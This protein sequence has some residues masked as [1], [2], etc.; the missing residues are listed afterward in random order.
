M[1]CPET[2]EAKSLNRNM[3]TQAS[4]S[5]DWVAIDPTAGRLGPGQSVQL[6][7]S[8]LAGAPPGGARASVGIA[9]S[10]G[11]AAEIDAT[12]PLAASP[13]LAATVEG[14]TVRAQVV[15][16]TEATLTLHYRNGDDPAVHDVGFITAT[17]GETSVLPAG[18]RPLTWWVTAVD[19]A[20]GQ[21]RT[22][23]HT[24]LLGSC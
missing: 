23:D 14:C 17:T 3:I 9:G 13:D 19:R 21:A 6:H 24:M 2:P 15:D 1:V 7:V 11:S 16:T 5:A 22:I 10:D 8:L 4:S 12:T 18:P 20:G